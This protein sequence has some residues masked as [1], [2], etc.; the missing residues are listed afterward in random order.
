MTLT[1]R[2]E[3]YALCERATRPFP[4]DFTKWSSEY[5]LL[6]TSP[7]NLMVLDAVTIPHMG[8][9]NVNIY[10]FESNGVWLWEDTDNGNIVLMYSD[11]HQKN[12]YRGTSFEIVTNPLDDDD[13][14]KETV[15]KLIPLFDGFLQE[16]LKNPEANEKYEYIKK[17]IAST[18][19]LLVRV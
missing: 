8:K 3:V 13:T 9:P 5:T 12:A 14:T 7:L 2:K 1:K 16:A 11:S 15:D 10:D 19:K 18:P 6:P 17:M 4:Y